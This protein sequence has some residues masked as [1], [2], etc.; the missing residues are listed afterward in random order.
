MKGRRME[1]DE[2]QTL[3]LGPALGRREMCERKGKWGGG[4]L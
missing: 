1:D 4:G 3:W 2:E